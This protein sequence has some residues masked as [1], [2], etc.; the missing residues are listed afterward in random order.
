MG[1]SKKD[2]LFKVVLPANVPAVM[3]AL[4]VNTGLS[5]IG[6]IIGEM[7][8]AKYGLGYLIIY[9]SQIFRLDIV[10]L[11][12]VILALLSTLLYKAIVMLEEKINSKMA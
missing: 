10:L 8:V 5:F 3:N 9:G 12:V 11:S 7:L 2:V 1:G 6:T 4:K